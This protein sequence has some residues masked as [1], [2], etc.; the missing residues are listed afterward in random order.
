[1]TVGKYTVDG[2]DVAVVEAVPCD[3]PPV[4]CD[5]RLDAVMHRSYES[6]ASVRLYRYDDR[7]KGV[8]LAPE[9][10]LD[11]AVTRRSAPVVRRILVDGVGVRDARRLLAGS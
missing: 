8:V 10:L 11:G 2:G 5:C 7:I 3:L 1:M 9:A 4:R 6:D